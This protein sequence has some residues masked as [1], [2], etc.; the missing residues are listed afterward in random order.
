MKFIERTLMLGCEQ[1][2]PAVVV[3]DAHKASQVNKGICFLEFMM[4]ATRSV[5]GL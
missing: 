3:E 2:A 5:G 1:Y 4:A